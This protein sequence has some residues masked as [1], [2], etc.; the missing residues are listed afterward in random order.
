MEDNLTQYIFFDLPSAISRKAA[1]RSSITGLALRQNRR[2]ICRRDPCFRIVF[3]V[4]IQIRNKEHLSLRANSRFTQLNIQFIY[5][6]KDIFNI[7][8][9]SEGEWEWITHSSPE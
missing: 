1:C 7:I 6:L 4:K 2:L 5:I 9:G 8:I 3:Y